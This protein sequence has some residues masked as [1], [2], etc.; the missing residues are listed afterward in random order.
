MVANPRIEVVYLEVRFAVSFFEGERANL[1]LAI[2]QFPKQDADARGHAL[3]ALR[4]VKKYPW[5]RLARCIVS[6]AQQFVLSQLSRALS[7]QP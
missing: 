6:N 4:R 7:R 2:V 5:T 3:V 1:T